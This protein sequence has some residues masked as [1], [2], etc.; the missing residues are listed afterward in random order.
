MSFNYFISET[1][2]AYILEAVRLVAKDGWRLL[3]DYRFEPA[4]GLWRHRRGPVE[5]PLRLSQVTYDTQ[6]RMQYPR[7]HDRAPESEL[8]R[9]LEEAKAVLKAAIPTSGEP[10]VGMVSEDFEQLR[11]FDLPLVCLADIAE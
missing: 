6:G 3:G 10:V 8:R 5:P 4:T 9:Y 7:H 1:V 11:W 2:F